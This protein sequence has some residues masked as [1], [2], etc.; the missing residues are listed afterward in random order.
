VLFYYYQRFRQYNKTKIDYT[1]EISMGWTM[2]YWSYNIMY[3][4]LLK[5]VL[6]SEEIMTGIKQ[7][8]SIDP[9]MLF[10]SFSICF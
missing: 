3:C 5:N 8:D 10:S 6:T 2:L 9:N 4:K 1:T 7:G